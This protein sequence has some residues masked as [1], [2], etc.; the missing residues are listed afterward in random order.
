[1]D[2]LTI[3]IRATKN[4]LPMK[5]LFLILLVAATVVSIFPHDAFAKTNKNDFVKP[6]T[7]I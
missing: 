2:V 7:S 6:P 3:L 5:R 4:N 1:M